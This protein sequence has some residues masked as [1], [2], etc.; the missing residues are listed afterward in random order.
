MIGDT[1]PHLIAIQTAHR[2]IPEHISVALLTSFQQAM[3]K[4][5]KC[6]SQ[7]T[8]IGRKKKKQR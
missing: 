2:L 5:Q 1:Y 8:G 3:E 7:G 6:L 4:R